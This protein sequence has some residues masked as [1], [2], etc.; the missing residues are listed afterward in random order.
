MGVGDGGTIVQWNGAVWQEESG[1]TAG[2]KG[3][4][5]APAGELWADGATGAILRR[6]L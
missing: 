3:V 6:R 4:W 2:L 1:T 5:G